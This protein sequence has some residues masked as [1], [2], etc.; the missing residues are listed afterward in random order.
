MGN[1]YSNKK[2]KTLSDYVDIEISKYNKIG[3]KSLL[4]INNEYPNS[5]VINTVYSIDTGKKI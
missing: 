3:L 1:G 2:D 5:K 4:Y